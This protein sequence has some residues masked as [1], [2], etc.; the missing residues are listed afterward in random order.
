MGSVKE[1]LLTKGFSGRVGDEIVFRQ[2]DNRTLVGKRPRKRTVLSPG[3]QA[4]SNTFKKAVLFAKTKLLDPA[5]RADYAARA[6]TAGLKSAYVAAVTDYLKEPVI[7]S[8]ESDYY[9]G[10]IGDIIWII[11]LVD[12]KIQSMTVTV[13]LPDATVLETG[14]AVLEEG[15]WKYIATKANTVL[16]GTKVVVLAKDRPG[17]QATLEKVL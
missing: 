10:A 15:R 7:D 3:T 11:S 4:Q 2:V 1:N 17:K 14:E 13:Y 9:T 12:F 5:I 6:K 16:A 8:I